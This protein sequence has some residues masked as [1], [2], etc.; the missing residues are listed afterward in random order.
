MVKIL[1]RMP[2]CR[3]VVVIVVLLLELQWLRLVLLLQLISQPLVQR[4]DLLREHL[5][6]WW[7]RK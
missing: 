5:L 4:E 2:V 7:R 6:R 3:G 1:R